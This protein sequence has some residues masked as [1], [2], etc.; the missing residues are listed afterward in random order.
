MNL[1]ATTAHV[2]RTRVR[3]LDR[4]T[5]A[6]ERGFKD[7][8]SLAIHVA[9]EVQAALEWS[10]EKHNR[11]SLVV[12]GG[13]AGVLLFPYLRALSLPWE[14]VVVSLAHET[15]VPTHHELSVEGQVRREL[16]VG[17]ARSAKFV[18]MYKPGLSIEAA[19]LRGED[20][21]AR[22]SQVSLARGTADFDVVLLGMDDEGNVAGL[23]SLTRRDVLEG[24]SAARLVQG[25]V[26]DHS[27]TCLSLSPRAL[28]DSGHT[29]VVYRGAG[30][31]RAYQR[32]L[33][34]GPTAELP[35]RAILHGRTRYGVDVFFTP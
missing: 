26:P 34:H 15:W 29:F 32:A 13:P 16:L 12:S 17:D 18:G 19:V 3:G 11:A 21:C 20:A 25:P 5:A 14:K 22:P 27:E 24:K 8:H 4:H 28:L 9:L 35:V 2:S 30:S 23:S 6:R 10:I 7:A 31:A 33:S 1:T